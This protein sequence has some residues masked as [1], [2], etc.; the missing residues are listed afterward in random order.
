MNSFSSFELHEA[1]VEDDVLL[2]FVL[3]GEAFEAEAVGF[4]LL[5]HFVGVR[6][7]QD[8][9]DDVGKLRQISGSALSTCSIPLFGESRPNV[10][11]TFL[12]LD[13]KLVLV[14]IRGRQTGCR[15]CHAG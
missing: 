10:S 9:V 2:D 3:L 11:N 4:A 1:V 5:A 15:E 8:D 14:I 6:R 12:P 7:A 13:A